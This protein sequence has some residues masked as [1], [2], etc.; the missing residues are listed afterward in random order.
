[1]QL[2]GMRDHY[3]SER[4]LDVI[5]GLNYKQAFGDLYKEPSV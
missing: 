2:K 3:P 1:M 4:D 5:L